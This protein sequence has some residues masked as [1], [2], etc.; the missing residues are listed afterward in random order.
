[1]IN[2]ETLEK[3][4]QNFVLIVAL[5]KQ[6]FQYYV[7]EP[8]IFYASHQEAKQVRDSLIEKKELTPLQ[9]KILSVWKVKL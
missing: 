4:E 7:T 1:M 2:Q 6:V 8:K 9:I 3:L 5:E